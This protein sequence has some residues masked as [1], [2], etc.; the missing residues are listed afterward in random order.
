M[1]ELVL[2]AQVIHPWDPDVQLPPRYSQEQ[3]CAQIGCSTEQ[4]DNEESRIN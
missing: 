3:V 1:I 4:E 2:I